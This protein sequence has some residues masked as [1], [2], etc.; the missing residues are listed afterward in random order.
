[1]T[2][3][4]DSAWAYIRIAEAHLLMDEVKP[5]CTA[6]RAARGVAQSMSQA[7]VVSDYAT[8]LSCGE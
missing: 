1:M 6:L 2:T 8:K 5:A 7:R 4:E 3:A